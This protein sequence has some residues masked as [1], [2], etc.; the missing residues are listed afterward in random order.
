M[1]LVIF[2]VDGTLVDS[3]RD[4]L[5]SMAAAFSGQGLAVPSDEAIR[6]IVGLSLPV[7]MD[8][9]APAGVDAAALDA[10]V[11]G[12]KSAYAALRVRNGA[13]GSP[14]FPGARAALDR[15]AADPT[16]R[17]AIATGKSRRGLDGLIA[18][19]GLADLFVST[20]VADN[21]PSKPHPAMVLACLAETGI[22]AA[23]AVMVGDTE[24]DIDMGRAA[25][26]RTIGV[27]WGY[28]PANRL[29]RAD[30]LIDRFAALDSALA[31]IWGNA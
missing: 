14:L 17:L 10:L 13:A 12:Y 9:L 22:A 28:H 29:S 7:A 19:H 24:F 27:R 20:Q 6:E 25:G 23:D 5:A 16:V 15:L 26:I 3:Q 21:H 30:G 11:A 31:R 18:A 8:R 4:I 1:K 2:D